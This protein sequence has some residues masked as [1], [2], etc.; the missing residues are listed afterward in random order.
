MQR[1]QW[2][3]VGTDF[4]EAASRAL[5]QAVAIAAT[6][7]ASIACVYAYE[8]TPDAHPLDESVPA[9]VERV[10]RV[11]AGSR[12]HHRGVHVEPLVRRGPAWE[13]LVNLACDLGATLI[14]V[15]S[16]GAGQG[17]DSPFLGKVA[18]R[19]ATTSTRMVLIVPR[20]M[21]VPSAFEDQG[22]TNS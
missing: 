1:P 17:S 4:S 5:D 18:S 9:L 12:A 11:I 7:R 3:V 10:E 13:K 8:D 16:N 6:V 21:D 14:V 19:V 2:I 22:T 20:R 15:G